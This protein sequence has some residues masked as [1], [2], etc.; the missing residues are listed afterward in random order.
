MIENLLK[1]S[2][3]AR[4]TAPELWS[5]MCVT[6]ASVASYMARLILPSD[7]CVVPSEGGT[8]LR[9]FHFDLECV[10]FHFF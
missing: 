6:P 7:R 9:G 10:L 3:Y 4:R 2:Y 5:S 8:C 1:L